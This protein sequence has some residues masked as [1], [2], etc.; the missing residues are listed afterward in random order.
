MLLAVDIGNTN[1]VVGV[2]AGKKLLATWRLATNM[3]RMPDEWGVLLKNM[4]SHKGIDPLKVN[5]SVISS[6]VPPMSGVFD[7]VCREYFKS[8]PVIIGAGV[9]TGV[10]LLID[11][12]R[13]VG[14]DRVA[15]AAAAYNLY[16][17]PVIIVD[18]GTATTVNAVS[19]AGEFLGGAIAPG[20]WIAME[21][22]FSRTS[23]LQRVDLVKPKTAIGKNTVSSMQSGLIYGYIGMVEG[24]ILR[25]QQEIGEKAKVVATGGSANLIAPETK[26]I[27]TVN[28]DLTLVGL[29]IIHDLNESP[30]ND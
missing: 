25:I 9:K 24:L 20:I 10:K 3:E 18:F 30:K 23:M 15:D 21:A 1:V 13:E 26:L 29:Q 16:G 27:D 5:Q 8:K 2:F 7:T 17:G 4:L 11:N 19:K 28:P 14:P 6:T 22:L 12:P